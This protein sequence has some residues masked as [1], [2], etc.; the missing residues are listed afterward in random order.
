MYTLA[1]FL[2]KSTL[3]C[4]VEGGR[5]VKN[6]IGTEVPQCKRLGFQI[7]YERTCRLLLCYLKNAKA[8]LGKYILAQELDSYTIHNNVPAEKTKWQYSPSTIPSKPG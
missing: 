3:N 6:R 8:A 7:L 2:F 4:R 5:G 1:L